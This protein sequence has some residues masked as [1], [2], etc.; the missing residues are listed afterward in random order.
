MDKYSTDLPPKALPF[1]LDRIIWQDLKLVCIHA[2][3]SAAGLD[4]WS[5]ADFTLLSDLAFYWLAELLNTIEE[6]ASWPK[7]CLHARVA[8]FS[9]DD[10]QREDPLAYRL[11]SILSVLYRKWGT[12]R[13]RA[14]HPW[15]LQWAEE[16]FFAGVPG[17]GAD[18]A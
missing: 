9:K 16:G 17:M 8:F 13:L 12:L 15:I 1:I 4:G 10:G 5:P 11:L 6:G 14:L 2:K 3:L 18:D 7:A